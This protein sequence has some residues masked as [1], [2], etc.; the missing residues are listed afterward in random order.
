MDPL[1]RSRLAEADLRD[2]YEEEACRD[3]LVHEIGVEI[4]RFYR[5]AEG[6]EE[7]RR[8]ILLRYGDV[9]YAKALG[10]FTELLER[11]DN[12]SG[13]GDD[14]DLW[15]SWRHDYKRRGVSISQDYIA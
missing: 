9:G 11:D 13:L 15:R 4:P 8:R 1:E 2:D 7:V 6:I 3:F 10:I 12:A 14:G 5:Y